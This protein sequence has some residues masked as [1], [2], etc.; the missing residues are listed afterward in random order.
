MNKTVKNSV[1]LRKL[2][3][4]DIGIFFEHQ[5]DPESVQMAAFTAKDPSDEEK[6]RAHWAK[7]RNDEKIIIRTVIYRDHVVGHV[8]SYVDDSS[9]APEV[10]YWIGRRFWGQGL[11]TQALRE[12]LLHVNRKRP[13][14]A[15]VAEDRVKAVHKA[16][17]A[18][19]VKKQWHNP[20]EFELKLIRD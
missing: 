16:A 9:G 1:A 7:I 8:L 15:R 10:S 11:A 12:F 14:F 3:D 4:L 18:C 5:K 20:P 6:F 13:I 19:W 17:D 2:R